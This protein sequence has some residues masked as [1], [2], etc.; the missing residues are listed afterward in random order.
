MRHKSGS[1]SVL[2]TIAL[3]LLIFGCS[4]PGRLPAPY[5]S[6]R[7]LDPDT[8]VLGAASI[9]P[10]IREREYYFRV[11]RKPLL[12]RVTA[13][14][15]GPGP[16]QPLEVFVNGR[17][18]GVLA[19]RWPDIS[20]RDYEIVFS[21]RGETYSPALY[22]RSWLPA[23]VL[24]PPELLVT[25]ENRL[26]IGVARGEALP[27]AGVRIRNVG[28]EFRHLSREEE[29]RDLRRRSRSLPLPYLIPG[30]LEIEGYLETGRYGMP[31]VVSAGHIYVLGGSGVATRSLGTAEKYD[32]GEKK[33]RIVT[34]RLLPRRYHTA[35]AYRGKIYLMGGVT[36]DP[37]SGRLTATGIVER[38]DPD[39]GRVEW[40]APMSHPRRTP[41]SVLHRGKIYVIGGSVRR[42]ERVGVVEIYD[43][44]RDS[45][46]R[47][48]E[49][50]TGRECD[51]VLY[52]DRIYAI[53][54]YDGRDSLRT[55]EVYDIA[56]DRWEALPDLPFPL[57][58]HH[59]AVSGDRLYSFGNY[60]DPS[61]VSSHDF[62]TGR[63]E[64]LETAYTPS[65][66]NAVVKRK[67]RIYI[68]GGN[69]ATRD[70]HLDYVQSVAVSF[71]ETAPVL[72]PP[73]N[74]NSGRK[75]D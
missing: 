48:A 40:V 39:T 34:D 46:S 3:F 63:W 14:L 24:I 10:V 28:I 71:L 61:M 49:M 22:S 72:R 41:I 62:A 1:S 42:G 33:S 27:A 69:I 60:H 73:D 47:G 15:F 68:I 56:A 74:H 13:E 58:A 53:G 64:I 21:D 67:G 11:D 52:R 51:A 32:P 9:K 36:P 12:A 29:I 7:V 55:F 18:A 2:S 8:T 35:Q 26:S 31:A 44:E 37:E 6:A 45:W 30:D 70:S 54:G 43:I 19:P 4:S 17:P 50:P 75:I 57:S 38:Y 23:G 25:G 59:S 5:Y 16:D 66:H 65:R 20:S